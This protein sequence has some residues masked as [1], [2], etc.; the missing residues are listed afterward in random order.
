MASSRYAA[1]KHLEVSVRGCLFKVI[2]E[3]LKPLVNA[4][5]GWRNTLR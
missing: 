3:I 4:S 5:N 1:G 2:P